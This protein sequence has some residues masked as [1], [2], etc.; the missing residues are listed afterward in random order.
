M[1]F[2]E[3]F[4]VKNQRKCTHSE[5][6]LHLLFSLIV[7]RLC[8]RTYVELLVNIIM[9][10][11]SFMKSTMIL[12]C[13]QNTS[14]C[15]RYN[16][17]VQLHTLLYVATYSLMYDATHTMILLY[18]SMRTTYH[19]HDAGTTIIPARIRI[20]RS[21]FWSDK[22]TCVCTHMYTY[23]CTC[24]YVCMYKCVYV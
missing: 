6:K 13:S 23:T 17:H 14:R 3:R 10:V 20:S 4:H 5:C 24:V 21:L 11:Y 9:Y 7:S 8:A 22:C 19:T 2:S 16:L 12:M 1:R 18:F 15:M